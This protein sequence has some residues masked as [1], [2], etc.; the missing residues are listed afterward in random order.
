MDDLQ[1]FDGSPLCTYTLAALPES[2]QSLQRAIDRLAKI[3][4]EEV[5]ELGAVFG[6]PDYCVERVRE[7]RREFQMNEFICYFNQGGL[8]EPAAV[9]RSMELF[10]REV[11]PHCQ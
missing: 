4:Y 6:D 7:L 11:I 10:A 1:F 8:I 2:Y 9:R 5:E 3:T